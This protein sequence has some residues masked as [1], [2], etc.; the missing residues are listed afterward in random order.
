MKKEEEVKVE[1]AGEKRKGKE[2]TGVDGKPGEGERGGG[3][4][5]RG[6]GGDRGYG[7]KPL[8]DHCSLEGGAW[9]C[10]WGFCCFQ[11][12]GSTVWP[13]P[14]MEV[15]SDVTV[16]GAGHLKTSPAICNQSRDAMKGKGHLYLMVP[17]KEKDTLCIFFFF[18]KIK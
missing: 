2:E 13:L 6:Q 5:G 8:V 17:R 16:A 3:M 12:P 9:R 14:N 10:P 4:K 18:L 1:K 11:S 7:Y 15:R